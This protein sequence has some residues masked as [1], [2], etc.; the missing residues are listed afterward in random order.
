MK[1]R[2][3]TTTD[4]KYHAYGARG[5][6][7]CDLWRNDFA[8]FRRWAESTGFQ[9]HLQLDR[10]DNDGPY[11]PDNCRWVTAGRNMQNMQRTI[12]LAAFG[13]RKTVSDWFSDER[14]NAPSRN[15]LINRIRI[16]WGI[17]EAIVT[18]VCSRWTRRIK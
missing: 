17:E 2:C 16:G 1:G 7:V 14:C 6:Y 3:H 4:K 12:V 13:E 10:I 9:R 11:A 18:P 8:E 15:A 5:I